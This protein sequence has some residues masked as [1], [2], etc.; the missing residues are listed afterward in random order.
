MALSNYCFFCMCQ[1][2]HNFLRFLGEGEVITSFLWE[3]EVPL[4]YR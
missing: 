3:A 2:L 1:G 4:G